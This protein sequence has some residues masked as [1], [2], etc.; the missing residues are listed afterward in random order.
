MKQIKYQLKNK[1]KILLVPSHKSPVVSV[2]MWVR[3]GSADE[4][5][6][7]EGISHFIEHLV[8]KGT[9]KYKVGEIAQLV[10]ASGGELNAYTSFDQ[11]VFYVTI[12][13]QFSDVALDVVSQM[14]GHPTFDPNE[15]DSEREVVCE[16][17]KMGQ[18]SPGRRSSQLLFSTAFKK[19]AYGTPV[20]GYDKNVRSW[21]AT[22]IKKYYQSRYVPSNMFLVVSGDFEVPEMKKKVQQ[23][24][25]DFKPYKLK[26]IKRTKEPVQKSFQMKSEKYQI[27]D[28][29]LHLTF[30]GPDAKHKDVPAL[31]VLSM[32][33]GQGDSS[34]LVKKMRLEKPIATSV[35][36]YN[37]NP[38]DQGL[39]TLSAHY[40]I[41]DS[42]NQ[43][44]SEKFHEVVSAMLSQ[45]N[46]IRNNPPSWNEIKR[47]RIGLSS[48]QFYSVETVDGLASHAGGLEFYLGDDKGDK[49]YLAAINKITPEDIH[50]IAKKYLVLDKLSTAFLGSQEVVDSEKLLKSIP[51]LWKK[52]VVDSKNKNPRS[53]K[54]AIPK[55]I[56]KETKAKS[57]TDVETINLDSGM[58]ILFK[59]SDEIPTVSSKFV[60]HGG[61]RLETLQTMGLSE[62]TSRAW[63]SGTKTKTEAELSQAVEELAVGLS[64]FTGKNTFGFSLDYMSVFE[65]QALDLGIEVMTESAFASDIIEREKLIMSQQIKSKEDQPSSLCVRQFMKSIF[66]DHP[67]AYEALGKLDTLEKLDRDAVMG[68]QAQILNPKNLTVAVV[69]DFN[70]QLWLKK[71]TEL[72]KKLKQI[73]SSKYTRKTENIFS[74][75]ENK[76]AYLN[77]DKEQ[78]HVIIGWRGLSLS[79]PN[80]FVLQAIQAILAGQGGRLF[81]EL[82]DKNSLAYSVSPMRMESLETG[83]FGGYIAC[84]PEKVDKAIEMFRAEFQKLVHEDVPLTELERAK[85]YLIGQHDIGLQK[86]SAICN[87]IVFD[88]VYGNDYRQSLH[89]A[90]EYEKITPAD[91]RR[92][93]AQLFTQPFVVSVVGRT[94]AQVV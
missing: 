91:I 44:E 88:E 65:G 22:K 36:A 82:R 11:T 89:V 78:S 17:I 94:P 59:K 5:A 48:E 2:Q 40:Q 60:F 93:S 66:G 12:S 25:A 38:K 37:Y 16:E 27:Q 81:Y 23:F 24:F 52:I 51:S 74:L 18:D 33:L 68:M 85:R 30:K 4:K 58:K 26:K 63:M 7:E 39:L 46:E 86:K 13:S 19:H 84:S 64:P 20:I 47:A 70:K 77:K 29:H 34:L 28:K 62:L 83:Y 14:M 67:L 80:R 1:M 92:L 61:A 56:L 53:K 75:K 54:I 71:M 43:A 15:I 90:R 87:L 45:I 69:G 32:L 73:S 50:K 8:F 3:T 57:E 76:I 42:A 10:E 21:S 49:K 41:G 9:D 6:K 31:D 72:E 55:I 79:D 35:S